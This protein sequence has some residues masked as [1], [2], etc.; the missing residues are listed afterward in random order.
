MTQPAEPQA[1]EVELKVRDYECDMDHVVNNAV[2]LNYLE[3]ARHELLETKGLKFGE[4]SR[5]GISLVVTRMEIDYKGSLVSGDAFVIRT[6][7]KRS[8]RIRFLFHQSIHRLQDHR[9]MLS[10][11]VTGT[12]LN[13]RGRPEFPAELDIAFD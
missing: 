13:A 11:V 8:G 2:Y 4:L 5:R 9:L 12:A 10:A 6:T 1:F 7:L 3:H